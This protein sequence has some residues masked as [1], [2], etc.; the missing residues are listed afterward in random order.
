MSTDRKAIAE[1]H[2]SRAA[3]CAMVLPLGSPDQMAHLAAALANAALYAAEGLSMVDDTLNPPTRPVRVD[4]LPIREPLE[5]IHTSIA[6][7]LCWVISIGAVGSTIF[8]LGFL[9]GG[10]L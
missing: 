10:A 4:Q 6:E 2:L 7:V 5:P 9:T 3:D 1:S 8:V